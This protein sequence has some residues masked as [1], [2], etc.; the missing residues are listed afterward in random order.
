MVIC[1]QIVAS[2][3]I[4]ALLHVMSAVITHGAHG[5]KMESFQREIAQSVDTA[6][7][8]VTA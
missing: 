4:A 6:T 8:T 7:V 3:K 5:M 2:A 1:V